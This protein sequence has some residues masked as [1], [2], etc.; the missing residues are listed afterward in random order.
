[1]DDF[2]TI[3]T[4]PHDANFLNKIGEQAAC[5]TFKE[6]IELVGPLSVTV[7]KVGRSPTQYC[8]NCN[9]Y[10]AVGGMAATIKV[11]R[12]AIADSNLAIL[13]QFPVVE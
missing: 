6:L 12:E 10:N 5:V 11:D 3:I 1:M 13:D 9:V 8:F 4:K 2:K 7:D